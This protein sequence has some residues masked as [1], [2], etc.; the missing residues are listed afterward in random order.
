MSVC[1]ISL[2]FLSPLPK[3]TCSQVQAYCPLGSPGNAAQW[4]NVSLL[5]E[6]PTITEISS[7]VNKTPAQVLLKW[8]VQRSII[9]LP[10]STTE[11]WAARVDHPKSCQGPLFRSIFFLF[12]GRAISRRTTSS[13]D[14]LS[15]TLLLQKFLRYTN[16][17]MCQF[18]S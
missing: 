18:V 10:K 8:L 4:Q 1:F 5:V 6:H 2:L 7:T 3:C 9:P 14:G 15:A 13:T 17:W 16:R 11:V 12:R